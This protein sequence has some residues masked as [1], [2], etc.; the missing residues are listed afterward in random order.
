MSARASRIAGA[1]LR[2]G[3][4]TRGEATREWELDRR[5]M[6]RYAAGSPVSG[7][8]SDTPALVAGSASAAT[9]IADALVSVAAKVSSAATAGATKPAEAT[10]APAISDASRRGLTRIVHL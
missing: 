2:G 4:T 10:N 8:A 6:R 9:T 5:T 1:G 3:D 7:F